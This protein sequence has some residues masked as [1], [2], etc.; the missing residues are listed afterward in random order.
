MEKGKGFKTAS[1]RTTQYGRGR[2]IG[3]FCSLQRHAGANLSGQ[4]HFCDTRA[5]LCG[6]RIALGRLCTTYK[7]IYESHID[8]DSQRQV[9]C[10]PAR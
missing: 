1:G 5:V 8:W 3:T 9:H 2:N 4:R 7:V 6:V 10:K